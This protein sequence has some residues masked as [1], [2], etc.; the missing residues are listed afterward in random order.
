MT[1]SAD[2]NDA[3]SRQLCGKGIGASVLAGVLSGFVFVSA[4]TAQQETGLQ[5]HI[6]GIGNCPPWNPQSP[7][8]CLN[9]LD[10]VVSALGPRLDAGP[11]NTHLLINEGANAS[12]LKRKATELAS[13]LGPEDRLVIY[14]NLPLGQKD[15]DPSS[16]TNGYV[17]EFW[18]DKRPETAADAISEGTWISAPAFAAMLH[19]IPAAEVILVLDTNNS[20]AINMHLLDTHKVDHKERPEAL[21]SSAGAGQAANYS[22][23]RTISL[24]AKH[25]AAALQETDGT[26]QDVMDV[27]VGGTRQAAIPI[28]ASLKEHQD[29]QKVQQADCQQVPAIHDPDALLS[30]TELVPL[31]EATPAE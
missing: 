31:P 18:A 27:A 24:F 20:Y 14:A 1:D 22:A 29:E 19:T 7:E 12:A 23:D 26:L 21:V 8:V 11:E 16:E 15:G 30:E 28:C 2:W 10:K 17:L 6:L 3:Q 5:N 9:S 13:R 25:L 4:A